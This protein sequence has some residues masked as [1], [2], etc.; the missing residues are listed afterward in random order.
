MALV[1]IGC[2]K[3]GKDIANYNVEKGNEALSIKDY[4][5]AAQFFNRSLDQEPTQA[6]ARLGLTQVWLNLALD[7]DSGNAKFLDSAY[8]QVALWK[9]TLELSAKSLADDKQNILFYNQVHLNYAR[10]LFFDG[11]Y[12]RALDV[13]NQTIKV[14]SD[15]AQHLEYLQLSSFVYFSKSEDSI[16]LDMGRKLIDI[17]PEF[18]P[19]YLDVGKM[20]WQVANY[21][22]ALVVWSV[23]QEKFPENEELS[24]WTLEAMDKTGW[25]DD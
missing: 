25:L 14:E 3:S 21:E 8:I 13:I 18:E 6:N 16:A 4:S 5:R 11:L 9:R 15:S 10:Y 24:Y 17:Y 7:S 20:Y 12:S 2:Q 19:A 23:G 1:L 22:E